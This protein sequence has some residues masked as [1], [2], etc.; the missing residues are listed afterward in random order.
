M[1]TNEDKCMYRTE[2]KYVNPQWV[3]VGLQDQI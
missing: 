3:L 2:G 1:E